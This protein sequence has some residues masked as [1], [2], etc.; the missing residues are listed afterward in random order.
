MYNSSNSF[1]NILR[2]CFGV[3]TG[4]MA[5]FVTGAVAGSFG[6]LYPDII[7]YKHVKIAVFVMG[8]LLGVFTGYRYYCFVSRRNR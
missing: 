4:L 8:G 2:N 1:E 3:F 7:S 6:I 5:G